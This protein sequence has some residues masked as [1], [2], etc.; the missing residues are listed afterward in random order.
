MVKI[1]EG[2]MNYSAVNFNEKFAKF[3]EQWSP[4]II[5]QMN[6][7]HFKLVRLQGTFVWHNHTDTDEVFVVLDGEMTIEFRNGNVDLKSGEMFVVPRGV[8][9]KPFSAKECRI[10][11]VER[12]GTINTGD[13][14]G[15]LTAEDNIWI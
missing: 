14:G 8:E 13:A 9:H 10:M 7:Y 11:L 15:E 5:A 1:V 3:S 2:D 12:A 4:K 6:D